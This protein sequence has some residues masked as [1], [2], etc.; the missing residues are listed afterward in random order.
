VGGRLLQLLQ[1]L[2]ATSLIAGQ[3]AAAAAPCPDPG[4]APDGKGPRLL[5]D[6]NF[7]DPFVARWGGVYHGYATGAQRGQAPVNVKHAS[8]RDLA[9]WSETAEALPT[10]NLPAWADREHV[11]VWAPEAIRLGG[12]YLLYFNARHRSLT[13]METPPSGP[14]EMKRHCLGV[15]VAERPEGPFRGVGAPLVCA[16]FPDGVI[17][18]SPYR[19]GNRLYLYFKDDGNCCGRASA[20]YGV[21]LSADGLRAVGKPSRLLVNEDG[22]EAY[23]DW[24]WRVVE[25]PTMVRRFGADWLFFSANFYGNK[26]YGVGYLKCAG[27]LGP[28]RDE[29]R[30]PILRSFLASPIVGPGHQS[31]L[32]DGGRDR[33][34]FHAWNVDPDGR[35]EP[36]VHKRCLY[37]ADIDWSRRFGELHPRIPGG[38]PAIRGGK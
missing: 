13:R 1:L 28:C 10:G 29:G 20:L 11:Q 8:S 26:N 14:V 17:D 7:P 6:R 5:L 23:D 30:N 9:T 37:V 15:A 32:S 25:A 35:E 16:G 34:F 22:P 31:I 19:E 33:I 3:A 21:R 36:G 38:E 18:A 2:L 12:R 24:E 4:G 27:P